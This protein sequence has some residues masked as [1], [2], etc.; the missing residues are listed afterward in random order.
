MFDLFV[1]SALVIALTYWITSNPFDGWRIW[2]GLTFNQ[3][4]NFLRTVRS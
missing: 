3:L 1:L 4:R 2:V